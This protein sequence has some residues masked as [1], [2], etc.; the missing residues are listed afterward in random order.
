MWPWNAK[1][2]M[3]VLV[4]NVYILYSTFIYTHLKFWLEKEICK[5]LVI[6]Y[7]DIKKKQNDSWPPFLLLLGLFNVAFYL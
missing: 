4:V 5:S 3:D 1:Q 7:I 6:F 2:N